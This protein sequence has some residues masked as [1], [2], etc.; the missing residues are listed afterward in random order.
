MNALKGDNFQVP[1]T[2]IRKILDRSG[3]GRILIYIAEVEIDLYMDTVKILTFG[4]L[5]IDSKLSF[6]SYLNYSNTDSLDEKEVF[7][8]FN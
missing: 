7:R 1:R 2:S 8:R 6:K 3:S 4:G 5:I